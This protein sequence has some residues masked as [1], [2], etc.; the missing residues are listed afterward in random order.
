MVNTSADMAANALCCATSRDNGDGFLIRLPR[1]CSNKL[2]AQMADS[3]AVLSSDVMAA[4]AAALSSEVIAASS[5]ALSSGDMPVSSA[6]LCSGGMVAMSR[7]DAE[8]IKDGED[9]SSKAS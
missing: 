5:S 3:A 2:G 8:A 7:E 9:G 1:L 4:S 6:V